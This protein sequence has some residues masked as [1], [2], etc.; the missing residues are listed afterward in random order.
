MLLILQA[1]YNIRSGQQIKFR[2]ANNLKKVIRTH[3]VAPHKPDVMCTGTTPSILLY[4]DVST[5][6]CEIHWKDL[7]KLKPSAGKRVIHTKVT[8]IMAMCF[9]QHGHKQLLL[10]AAGD[11]GLFA[12]D[13]NTDELEWE[14]DE[15]PG[16]EFIFSAC[17]VTTDGCG[18]LFVTDGNNDCIQ[19]FSVSG[20]NLGCLM[21]DKLCEPDNICW[22]KETSSLICATW[23]KEYKQWDLDVISVVVSEE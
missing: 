15:T 13:I 6:P 11:E 7:Q 21:K 5:S 1:N 4:V 8:R 17:G 9:V 2:D 14:V 22:C 10:V 23:S 20:R 3:T 16:T 12:Y 18:H 19:M